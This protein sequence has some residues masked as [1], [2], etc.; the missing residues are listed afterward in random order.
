MFLEITEHML[1]R[2][3]QQSIRSSKNESLRERSRLVDL[4]VSE[5]QESHN[6]IN[7]GQGGEHDHFHQ[8]DLYSRQDHAQCHRADRS[9]IGH[10]FQ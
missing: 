7:Q 9:C 8:A 5:K 2:F 4:Y 10:E 3:E 1:Q 6:E